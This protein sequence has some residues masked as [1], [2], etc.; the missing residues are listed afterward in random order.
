[1]DFFFYRYQITRLRRDCEFFSRIR[2]LFM[3]EISRDRVE[4]FHS[5]F[6][7]SSLESWMPQKERKKKKRVWGCFMRIINWI[8]DELLND[9]SIMNIF[10]IIR[11]AR[12]FFFFFTSISLNKKLQF[13]ISRNDLAHKLRIYNISCQ[14]NSL[15][16]AFS[17]W[18]ST[19][20]YFLNG[21]ASFNF[22]T[23]HEYCKNWGWK[24][25]KWKRINASSS[26]D[27]Y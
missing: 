26:S 22:K 17:S 19:S 12:N 11:E 6:I 13:R 24:K 5:L 3:S 9:S 18:E 16:F 23:M 2:G 25:W 20:N 21:R 15:W 27:F 10:L 14:R 4:K 1:M 7:G 8:L